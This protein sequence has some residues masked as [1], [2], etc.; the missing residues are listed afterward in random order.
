[1]PTYE[2]QCKKCKKTFEEFQKIS[3]LPVDKCIYCGGEAKRLV[4]G[5][6]FALKGRGWYKDSYSHSKKTEKCTG[7]EAKCENCPKK[8]DKK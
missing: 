8:E 2:Y 6:N 3:D 1:M 7:T 4:S 5:G